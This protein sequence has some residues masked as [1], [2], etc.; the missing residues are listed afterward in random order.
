MFVLRE[1]FDFGY[2]QI[3]DAVGETPAAVRQTAHRARGHVAARRPRGAVTRRPPS[4]G[5]AALA[6][7]VGADPVVAVLRVRVAWIARRR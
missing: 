6:P 7:G 5:R 2:E 1:V 3:A 4:S